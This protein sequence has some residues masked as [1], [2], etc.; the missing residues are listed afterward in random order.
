[1]RH[2]WYFAQPSNLSC[3]WS[4]CD[5]LLARETPDATSG[6]YSMCICLWPLTCLIYRSGWTNSLSSSFC[7]YLC[8]AWLVLGPAKQPSS[9][10]W[11][12]IAGLQ[13]RWAYFIQ[14]HWRFD[15]C[16]SCLA[17][18]GHLTTVMWSICIQ[19][20]RFSAYRWC[21]AWRCTAW[22]R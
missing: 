5:G 19:L 12:L 6:S 18:E 11:T 13:R 10:N 8:L 14:V 15:C 3:L 2:L 21:L 1:M 22:S 9:S 17:K 7:S 20:W 4:A 16:G